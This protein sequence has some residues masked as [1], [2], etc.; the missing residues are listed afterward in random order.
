MSRK[1]IRRPRG[2]Q[3]APAPTART[4]WDRVVPA[5]AVVLTIACYGAALDAPIIWDDYFLYGRPNDLARPGGAQWTLFSAPPQSPLAGRPLAV[6]SYVANRALVGD[7]PAGFRV[8]SLALHVVCTLLLWGIVR[9]TF[10]LPRMPKA[11]R[12]RAEPAAAFAALLWCVHPLNSE[13]V[14]YLTQRTEL[15]ASAFYLATLY[16]ALRAWASPYSAAWSIFAVACCACGMMSKETAVTAPV[17]VVLYDLAFLST[18]RRATFRRRAALYLGSAAT[19][20]VLAA[21]IASGPRSES[22]GFGHGVGVGSYLLWQ[23]IAV[24][25]Y[26]RLMFLPI[27]LCLDHGDLKRP[28]LAGS[29]LVAATACG[30]LI[31]LVLL[32][33]G[34]TARRRPAVAF[35]LFWFFLI[36]A[37]TSSIVPIVTEWCAERRAYLAI[38][39]PLGA[40]VATAVCMLYRSSDSVALREDDATAGRTK[41]AIAAVGVLLFACATLTAARALVYTDVVALWSDSVAQYPDVP[42][43]HANLANMYFNQAQTLRSSDRAKAREIAESARTHYEIATRLDPTDHRMYYNLGLTLDLLDRD[44]EAEAAF[45]QSVQVKP[46]YV[47]GLRSLAGFLYDRRRPAEAVPLFDELVRLEP[48]NPEWYFG[49]G[50]ST[51][52]SGLWDRARDSLLVV[53]Q[54]QPEHVES[55]FHLGRAYAELGDLSQSESA[56]RRALQL[57]PQHAGAAKLLDRVLQAA[58]GGAGS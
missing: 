11:V 43:T 2:T 3:E 15:M 48:R 13:A 34:R 46:D 7:R 9:R 42:R 53:V 30:A 36:L 12:S 29:D 44:A 39:G 19:W 14:V 58:A 38:A 47:N 55:W 8:Y 26:A 45:R 25:R 32:L 1:P 37:P 49:L 16:G 23:S 35:A 17:A 56:L 52:N 50:L 40:F 54:A 33:L 20:L 18:D 31:V 10:R 22:V 51:L 27:G 4:M 21:C 24:A 5:A 57:S 41:I 28:Y 6:F